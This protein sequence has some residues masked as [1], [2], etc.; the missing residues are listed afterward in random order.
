MFILYLHITSVEI[1]KEFLYKNLGRYITFLL[2]VIGLS[3]RRKVFNT[4]PPK[5]SENIMIAF[6]YRVCEYICHCS[7]SINVNFLEPC[8]SKE[9]RV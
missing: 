2:K 1:R 3:S 5:T 8:L 4:H 7:V 6:L 9:A